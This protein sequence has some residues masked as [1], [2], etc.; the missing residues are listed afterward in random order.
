[1][2]L[3]Y[4]GCFNQCM[5]DD[6]ESSINDLNPEIS[7]TGANPYYT[8]KEQY[9]SNDPA[10]IALMLTVMLLQKLFQPIT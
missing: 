1:M 2:L 4:F 8:A 9:F 10:Q 7:T 3:F 5:V 6:D